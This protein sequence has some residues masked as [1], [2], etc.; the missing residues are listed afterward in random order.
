VL[1][2]NTGRAGYHRTFLIG[3]KATLKGQRQPAGWTG[4]STGGALGR[5]LY[6]GTVTLG[7]GRHFD[8]LGFQSCA[9]MRGAYPLRYG[10]CR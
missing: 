9:T 2:G 6:L 1:I 10:D 4:Y 5:P 8:V 3:T 7:N